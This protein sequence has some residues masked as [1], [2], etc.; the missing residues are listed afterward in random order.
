MIPARRYQNLS[1]ELDRTVRR[2]LDLR[3]VPRPMRETLDDIGVAIEALNRRLVEAHQRGVTTALVPELLLGFLQLQPGG[4]LFAGPDGETPEEYRRYEGRRARFGTLFTAAVSALPDPELSDLVRSKRA[5]FREK[6]EGLRELVLLAEAARGIQLAAE[7]TV[8]APP[9]LEEQAVAYLN[10]LAP[11]RSDLLALESRASAFGEDSYLAEAHRHLERNFQAAR[12]VLSERSR[13]AARFLFDQAGSLF[14]SFKATPTD[15]SHLDQFLH[16]KEALIRY[17]RLFESVGD[18]DRKERVDG[19]VAAIDAGVAR[20]HK[21]IEQ[22]KEMEAR[23]S[24]KQQRSVRE[25]YARFLEIKDMY[26]RGELSTESQRKNA[27]ERLRKFRDTFLAHGQRT[28]GRDVE[29]FMNA[30]GIGRPPTSLPPVP[31]PN[32]APGKAGKGFDYRRGFYILLAVT[33]GLLALL[34]LLIL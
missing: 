25:S 2:E 24:E 34:T 22:Q 5:L 15:I 13:R 7:R 10:E 8:A 1:E 14:Q 20:L 16:Q 11:L 17:A 29:R 3:V 26:A 23:V 33:T 28:M 27:A 30:T 31:V 6:L 21:E 32:A 19:F 18:R 9:G 4:R 12:R